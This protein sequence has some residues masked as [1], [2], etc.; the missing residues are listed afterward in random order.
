VKPNIRLTYLGA[1]FITILAGAAVMFL[2]M[3]MF[4]QDRVHSLTSEERLIIER[5]MERTGSQTSAS[6]WQ[7]EVSSGHAALSDLVRIAFTGTDYLLTG[8]NDAAFAVDLSYAL[9][10]TEADADIISDMLTAQSRVRVVEETLRSMQE[11]YVPK[12]YESSPDTIGTT[13]SSVQ[14]DQP[15]QNEEGYGF[16]IRQVSG[17]IHIEGDQVRTDFYIDGDLRPGQLTISENDLGVQHFSMSWDTRRELPGSHNVTVLMRTSDGRGTILSGGTV[18][19]PAFYELINDG[20]QKGSLPLGETDVWYKLDAKDRN[21]YINFVNLSGDIAVT[22]YDLYG[23]RIGRNDLP[24]AQIEV[25][26]GKEQTLPASD[27]QDPYAGAYQNMFYARVQPGKNADVSAEIT[28]LMVQSKEVAVDGE[29]TVLAVVSDVGAVPTPIATEPLPDGAVMET[30]T[31]KDLN[32]ATLTYDAGDLSFLPINGRLA[33][34]TFI[35]FG[36]EDVMS[37]YPSFSPGTDSY[38]FVSE[39]GMSALTAQISCVEGYAAEVRVERESADG[40]TAAM[41]SDGSLS[42]A[43]SRNTIYMYVTDFD[44][45]VHEYRLYLLSGND[46]EGYDAQ[47]L[48][49]FPESYRSGL[50]L[51]HNLQP[52]YQFVPYDTGIA[53][54]DLMTAEDYEDKNLSSGNYYPEWVREDSPVYD[55]P[56]WKAAKTEVVAY[57]LDP[58]NFFDP[59]SIFQ[60]EKLSF[61]PSIHTI[62]GIRSM[63]RG[64]FLEASEPDYASILLT[65]GQESGA[66]P[67][68]LTSRIIQEM[69]LQGIS[70]LSS[71]TLPGYEGYFNFYNI[72][73]T[74]DPDIENGALINGAKYAMWGREPLKEELNDEEIALLL[75]WT[76]AD[77]AI[78]GGALWIASS[79][80]N[81]GQNTLYFQKFDVVTNEDGLFYHQYAQNVS[82][83][84]SEGKRYHEAYLSQ[85]ML[86]STFAFVIP[87]YL[88]M[89]ED[90]GY[91]PPK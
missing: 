35:P 53:W 71:G 84:Y 38:G 88:A 83:A 73:S 26:R 16:G 85:D 21:A 74:P 49:L 32:Q 7:E 18:E 33:D 44:M 12:T 1:A 43:P 10:G 42:I 61:D 45:N 72:G 57:F 86:R 3:N 63:V 19:I 75:P 82:M 67:Y 37:I 70:E 17:T 25:L 90:Y 6:I 47:T 5:T 24:G 34:I 81:I 69:G 66:S 52:A 77:L 64:S 51:L 48:D 80:I 29:G 62:E 91:L 54:T 65:A 78:R 56:D 31:C 39:S 79:Y 22:L 55:A 58:R 76:S 14:S 8:K 9:Y 87:V 28:Y 13:I 60:F 4:A 40:A 41:A 2:L 89:P 50:W 20:V 30:V 68:F 23:N 36:T 27:D 46:A 11:S 59:V 15:M